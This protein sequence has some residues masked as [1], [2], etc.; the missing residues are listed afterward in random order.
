MAVTQGHIAV[1]FLIPVLSVKRRIM[2]ENS[3]ICSIESFPARG[4]LLD[5]TQL[6]YPP[7]L[8]LPCPGLAWRIR[9]GCAVACGCFE[10]FTA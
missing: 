4:D 3:W 9:P 1:Y 6:R 2:L 7:S 5:D 10:L 8:L